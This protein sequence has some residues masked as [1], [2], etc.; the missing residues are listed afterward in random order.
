MYRKAEF[1]ELDL[2]KLQNNIY[3]FGKKKTNPATNEIKDREKQYSMIRNDQI[4]F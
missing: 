2:G 4:K 3:F 1:I